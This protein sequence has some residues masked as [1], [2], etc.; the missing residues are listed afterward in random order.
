[1]AELI[2]GKTGRVYGDLVATLTMLK[3][4]PLAYNKDM[5]EDKESLFDTVDTV[6]SC[7]DVFSGMISTMKAIPENMRKAANGGFI[8]ATDLADYLVKKGLPFR[9]AYKIC[10]KIV[11]KCIELNKDLESLS[12]SEY[13]QF[14]DLFDQSLYE[15]I[16]LENCVNKR[17]SEGGTSTKSVQK[18]ISYVK[19]I[20]QN[21]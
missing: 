17:V 20:L 19:G 2:R 11:A 3:G 7:L 6:I 21:V 16:N 4:L 18:Q 9:S 14:S 10:G 1:M 5:Q 15:H 12:L 8:N 13:K